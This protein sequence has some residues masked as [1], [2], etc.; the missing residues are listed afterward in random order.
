MSKVALVTA[1][2]HQRVRR[3]TASHALPPPAAKRS[4]SQALKLP[5]LSSTLYCILLSWNGSSRSRWHSSETF[6]CRSRRKRNRLTQAMP[7]VEAIGVSI[8]RCHSGMRIEQ[9]SS[10]TELVRAGKVGLVPPLVAK[11]ALALLRLTLSSSASG[12]GTHDPAR[13]EMWYPVAPMGAG[14]T[15]PA[16]AAQICAC[17][18]ILSPAAKRVC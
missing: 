5:H 9:V 1:A 4:C 8:R 6:V 18:G 17:V 3:L 10:M 15:L 12:H 2:R 16:R 11:L 14:R 7:P 13:A